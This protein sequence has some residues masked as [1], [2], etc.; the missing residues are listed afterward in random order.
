M[1]KGKCGV[2]EKLCPTKAI[3]FDDKEE[4][5]NREVGAIVMATGYDLF[6]WEEAYGEYG[7]GKYPDVIS[8]LHFERL[9]SAGDYRRC[10]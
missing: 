10:N 7:Y 3:K 2:C 1:T 5:V 9:V 6:N 8:G 4:Y